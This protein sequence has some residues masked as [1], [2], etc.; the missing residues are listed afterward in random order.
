MMWETMFF[1]L[2]GNGNLTLKDELIRVPPAIVQRCAR[3]ADIADY[4]DKGDLSKPLKEL[5]MLDCVYHNMDMY[6]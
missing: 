2:L 4:R 6:S 1:L 5:T 3:R